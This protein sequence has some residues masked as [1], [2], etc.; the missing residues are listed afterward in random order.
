M[1]IAF[2]TPVFPIQ[3][4]LSD[5]GEGLAVGLAAL[6]DV[7][8]DLIID[9]GYK[10]DNPVITEEFTIHTHREFDAQK[11]DAIIYSMGDASYHAYM[12]DFIH[13][14]PGVVILN[15]LTL[16]RCILGATLAKG[17]VQGYL[18]E[19][20]YAYG[21]QDLRVANQI[22]TSLASDLVMTYPLFERIVDS[23]LGTIVLN[24]YARD[25]I[26]EKRPQA[27]VAYIET[28]FFM[29]PGFP[30]FVLEEERAKQRAELGVEDCFVVGSF[31]IFVPDKHLEACLR[32]FA[33]V[34]RKQP[35]SKY[36]LVGP[37][38]QGYD[39]SGYI[40]EMGLSDYVI[41]TGWMPPVPFAQAMFA[42][43]VGIHLRYPHIGG[44]PYTPVRLMGLDVCTIISD[45][46]PLEEFP[47]GACVKI[48]PD[49]YQEDT[50]TAVLDYLV[51]HP[52][53][54]KQVA[55]NGAQLIRRDYD[56]ACVARQYVA[57]IQSLLEHG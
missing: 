49:E 52:E 22:H 28:P 38:V 44:T 25:R 56:V 13:R 53:F 15:D 35:K 6:P 19:M 36:I 34:V 41:L 24:Q 14:Y 48:A 10:P 54:R 31:G 20:R 26:L 43:D 18:E 45:I 7:T 42:L 9:E 55:R 27:K 3:S 33:H 21:I 46:E 12:L 29:P 37:A 39:L 5:I 50:L 1:K 16:H 4:A 32:A 57:F 23:S 47:Q 8:V 17:N 40:H 30:E 11:Y 2:F 51:E